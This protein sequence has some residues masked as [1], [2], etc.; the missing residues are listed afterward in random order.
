MKGTARP[1]PG[2][3][4]LVSFVV[5]RLSPRYWAAMV[6]QGWDRGAGPTLILVMVRATKLIVARALE[7]PIARTVVRPVLGWPRGSPHFFFFC[8][9]WHTIFFQ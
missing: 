4:L 6:A 8:S 5:A 2:L 3:I 1:F 7:R 9:Y